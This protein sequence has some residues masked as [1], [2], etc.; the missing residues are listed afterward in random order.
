MNRNTNDKSQQPSSW[1]ARQSFC[2]RGGG[3]RKWTEVPVRLAVSLGTKSSKGHEPLLTQKLW[4]N[5]TNLESVAN[6]DVLLD[7]SIKN[8]IEGRIT[9]EVVVVKKNGAFNIKRWEEGHSW[10]TSLYLKW[11]KLNNSPLFQELMGK[12]G[13]GTKRWKGT[14]KE[15]ERFNLHIKL[16]VHRRRK[17]H[18]G[19]T[20]T[21]EEEEVWVI[22]FRNEILILITENL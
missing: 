4:A 3:G 14:E 22:H 9:Q 19:A 16:Q 17:G 21:A 6:T 8:A 10:T 11:S 1:L 13:G 2:T 20:Q 5:T 7:G 18:I 12:G 15:R